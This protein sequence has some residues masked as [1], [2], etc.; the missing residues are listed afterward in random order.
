VSSE[1]V[2]RP[3][4]APDRIPS[5][6]IEDSL[7]FHFD[8]Q[9]GTAQNSPDARGSGERLQALLM[10]EFSANFIESCVIP[11]DVAKISGGPDNILPGRV[12]RFQQSCNV[13][14]GSPGLGSEVTFM[15]CAAMLVN[16]CR[17]GNQQNGHAPNV[18]TQATRK[19]R[20]TFVIV[21]LIQDLRRV[22]SLLRHPVLCLFL[23]SIASIF[24]LD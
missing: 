5:I 11:F 18:K 10:E 1:F 20:G 4:T 2:H 19:G 17:A 3:L 12:L 23:T 8:Q 24:V 15:N 9:I 14:A 6:R 13:L 21:R 7:R 22:D 16:A